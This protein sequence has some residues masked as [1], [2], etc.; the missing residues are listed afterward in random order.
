MRSPKTIVLDLDDTLNCLLETWVNFYNHFYNDD[1]TK[2]DILSW[3]IW[4]YVKCGKE[5]YD[6]LKLP[7]FFYHLPVKEG[8]Q[9]AVSQLSEYFDIFIV[10]ASHPESM[11]DKYKWIR[12][13]F[14]C[15]SEDNICFVRNKS[16]INA[17]YMIDDAPHNLEA[18]RG[19]KILMDA[20]HNKNENRFFRVRNWNEI[21][22][23]FLSTLEIGTKEL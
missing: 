13:Y 15:I 8:A 6:I 14:P 5:I 10:S 2:E 23:Y 9:E 11:Y 7:G 17:D 12:K 20:P 21:Q 22:D 3:D 4:K 18:F 1:L 16:I 19:R